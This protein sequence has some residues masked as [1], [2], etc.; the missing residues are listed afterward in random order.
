M[1]HFFTF[2][3]AFAAAASLAHAQ[4]F[5]DDFESYAPGAFIAQSSTTWAT[6]SGANGGGLDDATV[7]N[8]NAHSGTNSLKLASTAVGGGPDDIVLPFGQVY[9]TGTFTFNTWMFVD[10]GKN[11]Y[12]NYQASTTV[13]QIWSMDVNFEAN[14]EL[15]FSN[16]GVLLLSVP[17]TQGAWFEFTMT[18]NLN[19]STWAVLIDG[20]SVGTFQNPVFNIASINFYPIQN[21][22]YYIDDVSFDHIP[23]TAPALNAAVMNLNV[24]NGLASQTR[25]PTVD[26]RNLGTTAITSF[27]L[28]IDYNGVQT[29]QSFTG[30]NYAPGSVNT[31]T[32]SQAITLAGGSLPTTVT[33]SNVNGNATDDD[34]SDDEAFANVTAVMPAPGKTVVAEEATGTWCSW[35][36]RG[37]VYMDWMAGKYPGFFAGIAVHNADP[38]AH[39]AYDAG[40]APFIAGY[41]SALVDRLPEIDPSEIEQDFLERIV[42]APKVFLTNGALYNSA[43]RELKVSVKAN[44]QEAVNGSDYKLAIVLTENDV[45]GTG[46]GWS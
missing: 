46:S 3:I 31:V 9:S 42:V 12:M 29:T 1:K 11:A 26:V 44:W 24:E 21:S 25:Q 6:W 32:L 13:G 2:L 4:T 18:S 45:T 40:I 19:N 22:S 39:A 34:S 8:A 7:S 16:G 27:D 5:S 43:T 33:I 35:C 15:K 10:S 41:P 38:M 30:V 20:V 23:Y 14:G 37:A 28:A 36:P 17:Y